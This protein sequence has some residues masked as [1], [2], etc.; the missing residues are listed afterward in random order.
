MSKFSKVVLGQ[1]ILIIPSS[2]KV[3]IIK[4]VTEDFFNISVINF[5]EFKIEN[6][7]VCPKRRTTLIRKWFLVGNLI[8]MWIF[9]S[10][11]DVLSKAEYRN[12]LIVNRRRS[13]L[14]S[15]QPLVNGIEYQVD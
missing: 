10:M 3:K 8:Y 9:F 11:S 14:N 7:S 12:G 4:L 5:E 13:L 6:F 2:V 1:L 15:I